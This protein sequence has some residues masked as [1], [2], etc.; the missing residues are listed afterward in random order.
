ERGRCPTR[1]EGPSN[2]ASCL[3]TSR[4][5]GTAPTADHKEQGW[6]SGRGPTEAAR[7][8][9]GARLEQSGRRWVP[10][11]AATVAPLRT[12]Y[13]SGADA[14]DTYRAMA[15]CVPHHA[16]ESTPSGGRGRGAPPAGARRGRLAERRLPAAGQ[17]VS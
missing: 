3:A 6:D 12:L 1:Q 4:T 13:L 8:V 2:R 9:A 7:R 5:T 11:G 15:S 10:P 16:N 17:H 14:R